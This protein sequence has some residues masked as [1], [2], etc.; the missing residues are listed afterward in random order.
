M[1][2]YEGKGEQKDWVPMHND[3]VPMMEDGVPMQGRQ[4]RP[5]EVGYPH[6]KIANRMD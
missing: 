5:I 6:L 2:S 1:G 4:K 3:W